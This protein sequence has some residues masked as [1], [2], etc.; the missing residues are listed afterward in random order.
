MSLGALKSRLVAGSF[1]AIVGELT[2]GAARVLSY[3]VYAKLLSP[4]DFGLLGF[5]LLVI[6]LFPLLIDNSL[7]LALMRHPDEDQRV[8]STIFYLNVGL[9]IVAILLLSLASPL[10]ADFLHDARI[11]SILPVLSIQ[12]LFNALCSVHIATARRRYQYRRLVPVRLIATACSLALGIPLALAGY[13]YWALVVASIAS[14]AG[15]MIAAQVL[16]GWRPSLDFD[17]LAVKRLSGFTSWVA[18]DMGVTWLVMSGGGFFL[19]FFLGA[20][21][22]GLFRLSDQIDTYL[23]GSLFSPLIP[24]LY[25]A[26]CEASDER[27]APWHLFDRTARLLTPISLAIAGAVVVGARPLEAMLGPKWHGVSGVLA[28]NAIADGL[29]FTIFAA[30]SLL[31]AQGLANVVA[32]MRIA[33]VA[34]QM[35]VYWIVA[36]LGLVPFVL[37]KL[38]LEVAIYAA[39]LIVLR[40]TFTRPVLGLIRYQLWQVVIVAACAILGIGAATTLSNSREP[41]VLVAGLAAFLAPMGA[42]LFATQRQSV[43][44]FLARRVAAR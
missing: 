44:A 4:T 5:C 2:A 38:G 7:G 19:A 21:D 25:R 24:V 32:I 39:S 16:L 10:A 9:A 37:G 41:I 1:W 31:R 6:N 3:V 28:I 22:L 27:D 11:S 8:Y 23:M 35:A 30:P 34:A 33:T 42:I 40:A 12:L 43:A 26:F 14:A 13:A 15:Q 36:P 20:H 17:V 29:S 18:V